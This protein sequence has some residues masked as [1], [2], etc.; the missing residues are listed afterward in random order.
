[1]IVILGQLG[2]VD[3]HIIYALPELADVY[4]VTLLSGN[5]FIVE[6]LV[7]LLKKRETSEE[8]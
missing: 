6:C 1:M 2:V 3:K 4:H 8:I 5:R 7:E